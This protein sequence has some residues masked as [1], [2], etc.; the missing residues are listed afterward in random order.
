M[1]LKI[2]IPSEDHLGLNSRVNK[3]ILDAPY[4]T[5]VDYQDGDINKVTNI[6]NDFDKNK[7]ESFL[8]IVSKNNISYLIC[9]EI[10]SK[11]SN[12]LTNYEVV[13]IADKEGRIADIVKN[14]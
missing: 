8:E 2:L 14:F 3:H 11:L 4:F 12:K 1:F 9:N 13:I 6:E 10:I 7:E 5:L